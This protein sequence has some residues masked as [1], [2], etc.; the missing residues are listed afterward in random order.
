MSSVPKS[1][2]RMTAAEYLIWERQQTERHEF[3]D[4]EVFLQAGGTRR[5][6]LIGANCIRAIGNGL[7]D[8]G[9]EVH[10]SD[11]R[12]Y[13]EATGLYAY[14]D[15]SVVCPPVQG[16]SEDVISNPRVIVEVLSPSTA[17]YDRGGKF[18]HYRQLP[19]LQEYIVLSQDEARAEHHQRTPEGHWLLKEIVGLDAQLDLTSLNIVVTLADVYAKVVFP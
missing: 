9:C 1:E 6:S 17:D 10:G 19:S 18:G 3:L 7:S 4:G 14:P 8:G 12:V 5:H 15:V 11:M 16:D 2:T 13:I